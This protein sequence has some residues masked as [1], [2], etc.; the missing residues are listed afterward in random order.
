MWN[1][2]WKLLCRLLL[3]R[4]PEV[5]YIGGSDTLPP[6][7]SREQETAVFLRLRHQH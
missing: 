4:E 3:C 1:W 5:H 2:V 6:P 7:L